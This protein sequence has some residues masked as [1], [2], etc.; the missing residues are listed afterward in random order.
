MRTI[1]VA[2]TVLVALIILLFKYRKNESLDLTLLIWGV[3]TSILGLA[4]IAHFVITKE[5]MSLVIASFIFL[6]LLPMHGL[7]R[8]VLSAFTPIEA[9]LFAIIMP[10]VGLSLLALIIQMNIPIGIDSSTIEVLSIIAI[11]GALYGALRA[12]VQTNMASL[13]SF[14]GVSLFSLLWWFILESYLKV[15]TSNI[16][17]IAPQIIFYTISLSLATSGLLLSWRAIT[18]RYGDIE[19]GKITDTIGGLFE[20]MPRFAVLFSLILFSAMGLP[21]FGLFTGYTEMLFSKT[22]TLGWG[23][24]LI[25]LTLLIT[26]WYF[27]K[28]LQKILFG[29]TKNNMLNNNSTDIKI[30]EALPLAVIVILLLVLGLTPYENLINI[31]KFII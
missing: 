6:P 1:L 23:M 11:A 13:I 20:S 29:P 25:L 18:T 5:A 16:Q 31:I 10:S 30:S 19:I 21:P 3:A 27:T 28:L 22:T 12:L 8:A 4:S 9:A 14:A 24:W 7:Y 15:G 17:Q 2:I 26:S